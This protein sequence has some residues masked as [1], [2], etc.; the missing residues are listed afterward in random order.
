MRDKPWAFVAFAIVVVVSIF[1]AALLLPALQALM[2]ITAV[3]VL[4]WLTAVVWAP[5]WYPRWRLGTL[6]LTILATIHVP[7]VYWNE[8]PYDLVRFALQLVGISP[9]AVSQ[10]GP[11]SNNYVPLIALAFLDVTVLGVLWAAAR[12]T[13]LAGPTT[14]DPEELR[15]PEYRQQLVA[16]ARRLERQLNDI[17]VDTSWNDDLFT[18][19]DAE[20]EIS[21][22]RSR[23]RIESLVDAIKGDRRSKLFLVLGDPG[24]GKSIA[25]RRLTRLML[26][27]AHRTGVL[28]VYVNLKEWSSFENTSD[29]AG[30]NI[31]RLYEFAKET[32][33]RNGDLVVEEFVDAYFDRMFR[34][35]K[36]FFVF[37][38]FDEIPALLDKDDSSDVVDELSTSIKGLLLG[39]SPCRGIV[40]S[41]LY[42]RPR[43]SSTESK[44]LEIR[45]FSERQ[46]RVSMLRHPS[47]KKVW[48]D[49]LFRDEPWM[50]SL[51]R[52]PLV[53]RLI[54]DFLISSSGQPPEALT[55]CFGSFVARR[56][57][58]ASARLQRA[59]LTS[60]QVLEAAA[61]MAAEMFKSSGVGLEIPRSLLVERLPNIPV[62]GAIDILLACRIVRVGPSPTFLVSFVH[63][64]FNEYFLVR[65]W[66]ETEPNIDLS[67]IPEDRRERDALVLYAEVADRTERQR[68]IEYCLDLIRQLGKEDTDSGALMP[69][70][71]ALRFC[72]DAFTRKGSDLPAHFRSEVGGLLKDKIRGADRDL[73]FAK[74]C[75]EAVAI[76]E[77]KDALDVLGQTMAS[78]NSWLIETAARGCRY[79]A[80]LPIE[81]LG[82]LQRYVLRIPAFEMLRRAHDLRLLMSLAD[83]LGP[84]QTLIGVRTIDI[85]ASLILT[86]VVFALVGF[87]NAIGILIAAALFLTGREI[88]FASGHLRRGSA[89]PWERLFDIELFDFIR[90]MLC[91]TLFVYLVLPGVNEFLQ[92]ELRVANEEIAAIFGVTRVV[93]PEPPPIFR[94]AE[95]LDSKDAWV[96]LVLFSVLIAYLPFALKW[97][98][99]QLVFDRATRSRWKR[100]VSRLAIVGLVLLLGAGCALAIAYV[101]SL[102]LGRWVVVSMLAMGS[103]GAV[104]CILGGA[105]IYTIRYMNDVRSLDRMGVPLPVKREWLWQNFISLR[106]NR[107]RRRLL[108]QVE[109]RLLDTGAVPQG[110]WPEGKHPAFGAWGETGTILA[111]L[112]AK[113]MRVD[114]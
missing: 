50:I 60:E 30:S 82:D 92:A 22:R 87:G 55:T 100:I 42:R 108:E 34:A 86:P 66:Q 70:I 65:N 97:R 26:L 19:L 54:T 80:R 10:F 31:H 35:G 110:A 90:A 43:I 5:N 37:D 57:G 1:A 61:R 98:A 69:P 67:A 44:I 20:V 81:M 51:A 24:S 48:V 85:W 102:V 105:G 95:I 15:A 74:I 25:L 72:V 106:T 68:I 18:P 13:I 64:R 104:L 47:M 27:Q 103:A 28:P 2:A 101:L 99:F 93:P 29:P 6:A 40:A 63:R 3:L 79:V 45:P 77:E 36:L 4:V 32:T 76:V 73:I 58:R 89:R 17:D 84:V 62:D 12:Q 52:N 88:I 94:R 71:R 33:S 109:T 78:K 39:A 113:W 21:G 46:I 8:L 41:R 11:P 53:A 96:Q 38:S 91:I 49:R 83:S 112:E 75:S 23:R 56:L 16:M 59:Q 114:R 9:E 7:F 111:Q 107:G 14:R